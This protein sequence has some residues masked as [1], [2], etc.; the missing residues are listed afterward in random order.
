MLFEHP[1]QNIFVNFIAKAKV[2]TVVLL[3]VVV[4]GSPWLVPLRLRLIRLI[5]FYSLK[6]T[7][8]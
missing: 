5:R 2:T 6:V 4:L 3:E 8:S 1:G 7:L